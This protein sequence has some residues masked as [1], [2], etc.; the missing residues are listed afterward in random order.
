MEYKKYLKWVGLSTLPIVILVIFL[1]PSL[2]V[3][4]A[5]SLRP[6]DVN[7]HPDMDNFLKCNFVDEFSIFDNDELYP[8]LWE[9]KKFVKFE[10]TQNPDG[11]YP[12]WDGRTIFSNEF[13]DTIQFTFLPV[14]SLFE[15]TEDI[16]ELY[17]FSFPELL[18]CLPYMDMDT[19]YALHPEPINFILN[20]DFSSDNFENV[21]FK[22]DYQ[23]IIDVDGFNV[24]AQPK[25]FFESSA[26][27]VFT[28]SSECNITTS[29]HF[30]CVID[31]VDISDTCF[32]FPYDYMTLILFFQDCRNNSDLNLTDYQPAIISNYMFTFSGLDVSLYNDCMY[33]SYNAGI[34]AG[35][36]NAISDKGTLHDG[37]FAIIDSPFKVLRDSLN[38]EFLG[39]NIKVFVFGLLTLILVGFVIKIVVKGGK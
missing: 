30:K 29:I 37:I 2:S 1:I 15:M 19:A 20:R 10:V 4:N 21:I 28:H 9:N 36:S 39:V 6:C 33:G 26:Y 8:M 13:I 23:K 12:K 22:S 38:F 17:D 35:Y 27:D 31:D 34:D 32:V 14:F 16:T 24:L 3:V 25:I 5:K 11:T 18:G 7:L